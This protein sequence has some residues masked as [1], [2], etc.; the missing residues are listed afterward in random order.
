MRATMSAQEYYYLDP[1]LRDQQN[2]SFQK[3]AV[4]LVLER[5]ETRMYPDSL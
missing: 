4:W 1:Q 3:H 2:T 5:L